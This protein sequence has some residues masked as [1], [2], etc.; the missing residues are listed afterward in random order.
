MSATADVTVL[1]LGAVHPRVASRIEAAFRPVRLASGDTAEITP[2]LAASVRAIAA[3]KPVQ[4]PLIDAL[5]KLEIV[6]WFGVG[7][8]GLDARHCAARGI[9]A[10]NTP[11]VLTEEVADTA[12]GLLINAARGL[13]RAEAW[14][15]EGHWAR[16]GAYPLSKT[17]LRGRHAGIFGMGR[18]GGAIAR[19]LEALGLK[20]SYHNRRPVE[21]VAYDYHPTLLG[22]AR[23]VDTLVSA[24]PGNASSMKAVNAEIL[25]ALGPDGIFVNVGRGATVDEPA[26][27]AAL[28]D[29]TIA[30]AG[31]DVFAD[32]PRVPQALLDLPNAYLLPHISSASVHTRD[33]MADLVVDNLVSWFTRRKALTPVP[34]TAG[35]RAP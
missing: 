30:A 27:I 3:H 2:E 17:T 9:M 24:A 8:D 21:G 1:L 12:L 29:G 25:R 35:I 11:D 13:P 16:G 32:E 10:T 33:A 31:L 28:R 20:V 26:L 19:R 18:I 15:R 7:Y 14:L 22:L 4:A 5:P 34:E 23:S 6:S